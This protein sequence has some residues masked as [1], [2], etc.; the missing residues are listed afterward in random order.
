MSIT[1]GITYCNEGHLLTECL[2]SLS[3]QTVKP[4]QII[5]YDD[6]SEDPASDHIP[7]NF[8]VDIIRSEKNCGPGYGRNLIFKKSMSDYIHFHDADDLFLPEWCSAVKK[9][10]ESQP[11]MIIT[12]FFVLHAENKTTS[13]KV[14][15]RHMTAADFSEISVITGI[16][17]VAV[18]LRKF[19][20][21]KCGLYK[22]RSELSTAEDIE[23]HLRMLLSD[24]KVEAEELPL[25]V[26][27]IRSGISKNASL[28]IRPEV[29]QSHLKAV[30]SLEHRLPKNLRSS[31][32]TLYMAKASSALDRDDSFLAERLI[33]TS[34]QYGIP[35]FKYTGLIFKY[36]GRIVGRR[37]ALF[38]VHF[39]KQIKPHLKK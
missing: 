32:A 27:R 10:A 11:D 12:N 22:E 18:T 38:L 35:N 28:K 30:H 23:F 15:R 4:D 16:P 37:A 36:L 17:P 6:G 31:V 1:V 24:P 26:Y 7:E 5:I 3:D 14:Y 8:N 21:D 19:L 33:K 34:Y 29:S 13:D 2:K 39:L 20:I 9:L 25:C